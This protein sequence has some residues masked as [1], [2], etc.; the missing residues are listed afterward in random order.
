MSSE[1]LRACYHLFTPSPWRHPVQHQGRAIKQ[2]KRGREREGWS[3]GYG[4]ALMQ[5]PAVSHSCRSKVRGHNDHITMLHADFYALI[6]IKGW[7][8]CKHKTRKTL[9]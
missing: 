3:Y 4:R 7:I 8:K 9:C 1:E 6:E 5:A 2:R